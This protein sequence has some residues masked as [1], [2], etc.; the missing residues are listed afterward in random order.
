MTRKR[1]NGENTGRLRLPVAPGE[2]IRLLHSVPA[3]FALLRAM[4]DFF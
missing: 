3:K 1:K 4:T 2:K